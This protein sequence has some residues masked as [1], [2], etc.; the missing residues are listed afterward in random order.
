M[1][2]A[3]RKATGDK[4]LLKLRSFESALPIALLR[5]RASTAAKFKV[6]TD[7]VGITQQQWRV[8]R[9]LAEGE[10]LD[11]GTVATRC[12]LL[13]PSVSRLLKSLVDRGLVEN[14]PGV[15]TDNR[16]RELVITAKG[17]EVFDRIAVVSEAVYR[18]IEDAFGREA[19]RDLIQT[20]NRLRDVVDAMPNL[21]LEMPELED[22]SE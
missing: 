15:G 1:P 4:G 7:S 13:Q 9:V 20:L 17:M 16:R 19:L 2:S 8:I 18:D 11:V 6:H 22:A 3:G 5:A 21:P 14:R 12:A 10:P